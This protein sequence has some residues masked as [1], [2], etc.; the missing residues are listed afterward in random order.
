MAFPGPGS[1]DGA[2]PKT[3]AGNRTLCLRHL[4]TG[5]NP[6]PPEDAKHSQLG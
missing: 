2:A 3:G 4:S 6:G 5:Q 1:G